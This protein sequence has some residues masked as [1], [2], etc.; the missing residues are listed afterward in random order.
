MLPTRPRDGARLWGTDQRKKRLIFVHVPKCGGSAL[1]ATFSLRRRRTRAARCV[2]IKF[3][4][5]PIERRPPCCSN[6]GF[7]QRN[8]QK[9]R[10]CPDVLN[11]HS[12]Q[13]Q[14]VIFRGEVSEPPPQG[15]DHGPRAL[16]TG[17][18]RVALPLPQPEL[19]LFSY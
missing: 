18:E 6:P 14:L 16:G 3:R 15:R 4:T 19:G 17:R 11:C 7:C 5:P 1:T 9:M 10:L 13:P 12:H 8:R 2:E